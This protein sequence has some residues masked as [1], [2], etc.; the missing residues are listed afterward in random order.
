MEVK[1]AIKNRRLPGLVSGLLGEGREMRFIAISL[2]NQSREG[3]FWVWNSYLVSLWI[4]CLTYHHHQ[5]VGA[6]LQN[7]GLAGQAAYYFWGVCVKYFLP[8][9]QRFPEAILWKL[10]ILATSSSPCS[11]LLST[12]SVIPIVKIHL[13]FDI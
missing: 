1:A 12:N 4:S 2:K 3:I 5:F 13:R 6:L 8:P 7:K 10:L 11:Y 9:P